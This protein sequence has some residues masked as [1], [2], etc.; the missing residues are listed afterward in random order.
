MGLPF[1]SG[2]VL[3]LRHF[4]T[5]SI[6][7][8]YTS[9]W[10]RDPH[11]N[12]VF[13]ADVAPH[14]SCSRYFDGAVARSERGEITVT[15]NGPRELV[16]EVPQPELVWAVR[17]AETPV[18]RLVNRLAAAVPAPL[19]QWASTTPV[20]PWIAARALGAGRLRLRGR[21]PNGWRFHAVPRAVWVI[22]ACRAWIGD[23]DLGAPGHVSPQARLGDFLIPQR[24]LFVAGSAWF[25]S[26]A[27][28]CFVATGGAA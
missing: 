24:G 27:V 21:T 10:H 17:L 20:V 1:T 18:T 8:G 19:W 9:V 28:S 3:A 22:E 7:P 14:N 25:T 13:Y 11:G 12:W 5:S 23:I 15:W 26:G 4:P 16:V 2:H 6:G